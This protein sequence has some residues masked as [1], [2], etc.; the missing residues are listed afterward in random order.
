ML[1][2]LVSGFFSAKNAKDNRDFQERMSNTAHQREAADLEAAGLNRILS[3]TNGGASTPPGAVADTP[4]FVAANTAMTARKLMKAQT[5][6][7]KAD[8]NKKEAEAAKTDAETENVRRD[9][10]LKML[11]IQREAPRRRYYGAS[12]T[13]DYEQKVAGVLNTRQATESSAVA[14]R[15]QQLEIDE[16]ARDPRTMG[17]ILSKDKALADRLDRALKGDADAGEYAKILLE[18]LRR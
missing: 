4:D 3:V 7:T 1:D 9:G 2:A 17:W 6:A 18:A 12:A 13:A 16:I 11:E 10:V 15:R 14:T 8:A 5:I